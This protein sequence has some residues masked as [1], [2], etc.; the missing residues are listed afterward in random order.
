[1][2]FGTKRVAPTP[3][4]A[5]NCFLNCICRTMTTSPQH[6]I[7][8]GH[9]VS[10]PY[11]RSASPS[12]PTLASMTIE[13][14]RK[15]LTFAEEEVRHHFVQCICVLHQNCPPSPRPPPLRTRPRKKADPNAIPRPRNPFFLFRADHDHF[16]KDTWPLLSSQE[17]SCL[18][19]QLWRCSPE[20]VKR[21]Y[22]D[23]YEEECKRHKLIWP[24]YRYK[25][26]YL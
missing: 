22:Y 17:V 14:A 12:S 3:L 23:A 16:I 13:E 10:N 6:S 5:I 2:R 15:F 11:S 9:S 7:F 25:R 8:S 26:R 19:A 24:G 18:V 1:M 4:L 20:S 21:I